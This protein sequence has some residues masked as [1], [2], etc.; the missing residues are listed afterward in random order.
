M[1]WVAHLGRMSSYCTGDGR[2]RKRIILVVVSN[3]RV[4]PSN[5]NLY[6]RQSRVLTPSSRTL[7]T[8][9]HNLVLQYTIPQKRHCTRKSPGYPSQHKVSQSSPIH[10]HKP[11][12][13]T[14]RTYT[15]HT[16]RPLAN[17]QSL[18]I[19]SVLKHKTRERCPG[20]SI[21]SYER[22]ASLYWNDSQTAY[23]EWRVGSASYQVR[24][25]RRA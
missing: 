18:S 25:R 16:F 17:S 2:A 5:R 1:L 8:R 4:T 21:V 22:T 12:Y 10:P 14:L 19:Q 7:S 15:L 24:R 13:H 20:T 9:C 6:H 3:F 11:S 23:G